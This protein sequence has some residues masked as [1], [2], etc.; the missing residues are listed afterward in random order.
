MA[1]IF[2]NDL[3]AGKYVLITGG[4]SGIGLEIGKYLAAHGAKIA[5]L[6][7]NFQ[8]L[9]SVKPDFPPGSCFTYQCDVRDPIQ[10]SSVIK[11]ILSVFPQIDVLVNNAAGNFLCAFAGLSS[12]GFK[13]VLEI[14]TIGT[15]NMTKE[16]FTQ[17]MSKFRGGVI[18]NISS[19]LQ[20]P[21]SYMQSHSAAAK[22]AIDSLTRSL[23]CE[24]GPKGIRVVGIAPGAIG[25]TEGFDRLTPQK[26]TN[27]E[28]YIPLQRV[29][30]T[31]EIAEGILY[32]VAA[33]Y[34]TGHT[35]VVDGGMALSF[36][37][38][39]LAFP[40]VFNAWKSKI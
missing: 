4:G 32:L 33:Q 28:D 22:A 11:S 10:I 2:R 23:A 29:G 40:D 9:E 12:K 24:L 20:M 36:P 26:G 38:F 35:L 30:T 31:R 8:K 15:F 7:R 13:T 16:V 5:I 25:G 39:T 21:C 17:S 14:D 6:G 27:M 34:V 1:S 19:L 37:N 3:M 18:V